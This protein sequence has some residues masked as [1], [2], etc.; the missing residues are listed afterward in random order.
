MLDIVSISLLGSLFGIISGLIP[1]VGTFT[2]VALS[3]PFLLNL[4]ISEIIIF[5][6]SLVCSA[7]YF[8]SVTAIHCG[9]AGEASSF[10]AVIEG[11]KLSAQGQAHEAIVISGIGSFIGTIVGISFLFLVSI[12]GYNFVLTTKQSLLLFSLV[13]L[14]LVFVSKNKW[15]IDAGLIVLALLLCH[16]GFDLNNNIPKTNFN[17]DWLSKGFSYFSLACS[18]ICMKE[19]F[20]TNDTEFTTKYFETPFNKIKMFLQNLG[21]IIRGSLIGS[22]GG[23][24]PGITTI[25]SSHL[26]YSYEKFKKRKSYNPGDMNCL[27]SSE[28]ANNSGAITSLIPLLVLG[29]PI[30]GSESI[31]Y[32]IL[33][34]K[35]WQLKDSIPTNFFLEYWYI[36]VIVNALSLFFAIRF[37]RLIVKIIPKNFKILSVG[38]FIIL[39]STVY[40]VG[41][42][43]KLNGIFDAVIFCIGTLI[44]YNFRKI[45]FLPFV[46]WM[47]V[48]ELWLQNFYR[49]LQLL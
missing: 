16:V 23:L 18:L 4:N 49:Y 10:P 38:L 48:G 28:T 31:I 45:N 34:S 29:I 42:S 19:I 43:V 37:S 32:I 6:F 14:S 8:G 35:Q 30:T 33:D 3:Y 12:I 22:I 11:R 46:F 7:Q 9:I 20:S 15:Y 2:V 1:G 13:G 5:Y 47:V 26:A 24:V 41:E 21:S 27:T 25:A 36:L 40:L 17:Q 44:V 39:L